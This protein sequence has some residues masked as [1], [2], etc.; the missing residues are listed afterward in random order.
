ML[1]T[2]NGGF[3]GPI[4][5]ILGFIMDAIFEFCNLLTIPSIGLTIILFTIIIYM[6]LMPLTI[7]QQKFP[8]CQQ[9]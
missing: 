8:S 2:K 4:A 1:L 5:T 6:L 7:K 9:R 3:L